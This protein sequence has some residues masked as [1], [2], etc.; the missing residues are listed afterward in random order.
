MCEHVVSMT[1]SGE[2]LS[3]A[4]AARM[5]KY[6]VL[7]RRCKEVAE[8]KALTEVIN[9]ERGRSGFVLFF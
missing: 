3:P 6:M 8:K 2:P 4:M 9:E 1:S 7:K 5:I